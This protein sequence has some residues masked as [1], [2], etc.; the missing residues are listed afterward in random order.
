MSICLGK[1]KFQKHFS[2]LDVKLCLLFGIHV[3]MNWQQ[4]EF[5]ISTDDATTGAM[6]YNG[7]VL[8]SSSHKLAPSIN[9]STVIATN[10]ITPQ[11][12]DYSYTKR[13]HFVQMKWT[14]CTVLCGVLRT[15]LHTAPV[16]V[17]SIKISSSDVEI[18]LFKLKKDKNEMVF[19]RATTRYGSDKLNSKNWNN[20][21]EHNFSPNVVHGT[22]IR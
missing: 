11:E 7:S 16:V 8:F 2:F 17:L 21:T 6:R 18:N 3:P 10:M 1:L 20:F 12:Y 9:A 14:S 4:T 22:W 19:I 15:T 13:N 5:I